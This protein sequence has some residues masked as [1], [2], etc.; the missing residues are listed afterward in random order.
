MINLVKRGT[1]QRIKKGWIFFC[2][3]PE[4]HWKGRYG[5]RDCVAM[6]VILPCVGCV[7]IVD[8]KL[9]RSGAGVHSSMVELTS[10]EILPFHCLRSLI[11][12]TVFGLAEFLSVFGYV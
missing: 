4:E 1:S 9:D 8:A 11:N 2:A 6:N 5:L 10:L 3:H 7:G 12:P